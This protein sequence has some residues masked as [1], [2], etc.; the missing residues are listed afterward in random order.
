MWNDL[1][2]NRT[3]QLTKDFL[4]TLELKTTKKRTEILV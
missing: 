3:E 1:Y 4:K 2:D